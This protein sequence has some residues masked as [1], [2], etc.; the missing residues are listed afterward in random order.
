MDNTVVLEPD[1]PLKPPEMPDGTRNPRVHK[2]PRVKDMTDEE[3]QKAFRETVQDL[4]TLSNWHVHKD[5]CWKHLKNGEPRDDNSCRM[6][7]NGS[8]NPF[9]R[10]DPETESIILKRLHP[11]IN[12]YNELIIFILRCN[13]DIKYIGSGE[14]AKTLVYYVTDYITKGAASAG[15]TEETVNRSLFTKTV[16]ALMSKQ[17]MSHQ[18]VMSYLIG[19]GDHYT[20]HSFKVVKWGQIDR[21]VAALEKH[22]TRETGEPDAYMPSDHIPDVDPL[23]LPPCADEQFGQWVE[24]PEDENEQ[25]PVD[26]QVTVVVTDNFVGVSKNIPD[27]PSRALEEPFNSL[28]LWEHE[29]CVE[30]ISAVTED[31]RVEKL[32][33]AEAAEVTPRKRAGRKPEPRGILPHDPYHVTRMRAVPLVNVLLGEKIPRPD[34]GKAEHVKWCRAM[35]ILFKP[36]RNLRDLKA[37]GQT[38]EEAYAA[39][40]FSTQTLKIMRN[41]NVENECKDARDTHAALVKKGKAQSLLPGLDGSLRTTDVESLGNALMNDPSLDSGEKM[42]DLAKDKRPLP[43]KSSGRPTKRRRL[44]E[45]GDSEPSTT[46]GHLEWIHEEIR[47]RDGEDIDTR[48]PEQHLQDIIEEKKFENNPEQLRA[49][50]IIA[51]HFMFGMEEQLLLHIAGVGGAGKSFVVKAVVAFFKRCGVSERMMLN[52]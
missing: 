16:M 22:Q 52:S 19:G 42:K 21:F 24:D 13:M 47:Q 14:A 18:Q 51:E 38:W 44:N 4:V 17:E 8:T 23:L 34:R 25:A 48:T 1:G 43:I 45:E 11:R 12:N 9:T 36:W 29:E 26:E 30:K 2:E 32:E 39:T 28:S 27:Y 20:S 41:M 31:R 49:L 10:V 33:A 35:L 6:H 50:R 5:T 37:V 3:F 15:E 46:V 7:I 40:T